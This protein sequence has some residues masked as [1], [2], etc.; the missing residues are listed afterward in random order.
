MLPWW[1]L[2]L[3]TLSQRAL[4]AD[5]AVSIPLSAPSSATSISPA[6]VGL[7]L[8]QDRWTDWVGATSRNQYFYNVLDNIRILTGY[9][10]DIRIGANSEDH[11]NFRADIQ[12]G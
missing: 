1:Y 7:S 4:C 3:A 5:V 11:T 6:L 2:V 9:T 8:E 10:P 12:V